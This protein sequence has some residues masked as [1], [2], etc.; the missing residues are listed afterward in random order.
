MK[1]SIFGAVLALF[2]SSFVFISCSFTTGNDGN[3]GGTPVTPPPVI[4]DGPSD[5]TYSISVT[6]TVPAFSVASTSVQMAK[7]MAAGWNLGNT[8][9]APTETNWGMPLTTQAMIDEVYAV[10]FRT[11]RIPVSWSN[12]VD[13]SYNINSTWMSIF[14]KFD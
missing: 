9:D 4:S 5:K 7:N 3:A 11:I 2:I 8:L 13:D 1:K 6:S 12:H 14:A 10:G